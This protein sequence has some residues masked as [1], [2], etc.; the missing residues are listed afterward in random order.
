VPT[1]DDAHGRLTN[2]T[3]RDDDAVDPE[4]LCA[5]EVPLF[6]GNPRCLTVVAEEEEMSD[7]L[8]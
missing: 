4:L 5:T 6:L 1:V 3:R 8:K 7:L 2:L